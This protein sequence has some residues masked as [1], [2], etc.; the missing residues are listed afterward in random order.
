MSELMNVQSNLP[1]KK[2]VNCRTDY[3]E[4]IHKEP[5]VLHCCNEIH[6]G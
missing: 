6:Y 1:Q 5:N 3:I 2:M 4:V